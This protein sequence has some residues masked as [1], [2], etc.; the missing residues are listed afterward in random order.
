M[1]YKL[2]GPMLN[3][4]A[5]GLGIR[6]PVGKPALT[7]TERRAAVSR[8]RKDPVRPILRLRDS[9]NLTADQAEQLDAIGREYNAR[10]DTALEPLTK[11]VVKKG[12]RIADQDLNQRLT[13]AQ[14][15][16]AK[17]NTEYGKKAQG[18]LTVE[19][20]TRMAPAPTPKKP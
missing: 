7:E 18:V 6:E 1:E 13:V 12:K 11:W 5:R 9:L 15:A 17:L 14:S 16:L 8:L 10:A 4:I 20:Q 2:G 19:Q 3:P